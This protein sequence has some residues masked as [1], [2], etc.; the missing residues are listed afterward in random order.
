[1]TQSGT[2]S[3][4]SG[5]SVTSG[6]L[7]LTF[8]ANAVNLN[9]QPYTGTV[10]VYA[11]SLDP[12]ST[13]MFDRMPG[14]L[15]GGMNDSLRLLRSFGMAS[16]ELRDANMNE[17]QLATGVSATLT[18]NI[19]ASLQAEA[20][21][22]I[23][24]W[25]FDEILGYWKHEGEAQKTGSQYIGQATHFSWWNLDIPG[26]FNEFEGS[27]ITAGAQP[28]SN[29]QIELISPSFGSRNTYTNSDGVFNGR[30]PKNETLTLNINLICTTTN[31]WVFADSESIISEESNISAE[32]TAELNSY[33]PV[34][35][36]LVNCDNQPVSLGYVRM[37]SQAYFT[38]EVGEFTIQTCAVGEYVI[39]GY[40]T[41]IADSIKVSE[42]ITV[43]VNGSGANAGSISTCL[44]ILGSV[45]DIDGNVYETVLIGNQWWMAE[46][47]RTANYSNGEPIPNVT[48]N[49]AW[50]QL[51]SGAWC[52]Y[53][54]N[55]ANDAVYGKLYNWY[56]TIDP[57][58]LCP[59]GWHVPSDFEWNTLIGNLDPIF[60]PSALN[61]QST[62]AGGKMKSTGTQYW[63]SPNTAANNESGFS[64]L[65][66]GYR[67]GPFGDF[68]YVG[69]NGFWWSSSESTSTSSLGRD[70]YYDS[71]DAY[72]NSYNLQDGFSVRC[73]MD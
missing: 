20:P 5:G 12:S 53:S 47:L 21:A 69:S 29:A 34:S 39:R 2:F 36:T 54:N 63:L 19:P 7:Q 6:L 30:I 22:T 32:F 55:A 14:E 28:V 48:D 56:T 16:V 67:F 33:F 65:P 66:G 49:T 31:D 52:N 62:T 72:R 70:L 18:F 11:A 3:A 73:L 35:G 25:S 8:P 46:N 4:A 71:G 58:G 61:S 43:Q 27:V 15:L 45:T 26:T 13:N 24:W 17:L 9:G 50:T 57:R 10:S 41:S 1:M 44:S 40:D 38:N 60:D 64:G 51:N 59:A 23:D 68:Y 37:G 42:L